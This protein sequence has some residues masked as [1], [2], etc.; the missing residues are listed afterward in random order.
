MNYLYLRRI[1]FSILII[2]LV[3]LAVNAQSSVK[4]ISKNQTKNLPS[5]SGLNSKRTRSKGPKSPKNAKREQERNEKRLKKESAEYIEQSRKRAYDIQ[6]PEV[7]ARMRQNEKDIATRDK[8]KKKRAKLV[9]RKAGRR[10][11]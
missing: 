4:S 3:P 6:T 9:T 11:T 2:I 8:E 5:K 7:Q 1:L 10:Y